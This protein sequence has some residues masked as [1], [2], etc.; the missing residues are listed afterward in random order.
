LENGVPELK[1]IFSEPG[2]GVSEPEQK[3]SERGKR[4]TE[5]ENLPENN[6]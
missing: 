4:V 1:I 6:K 2:K 5:L 3:V